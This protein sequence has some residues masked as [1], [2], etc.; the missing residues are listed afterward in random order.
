MGKSSLKCIYLG[1]I[2]VDSNIV[3]CDVIQENNNDEIETDNVTL[4]ESSS[5]NNCNCQRVQQAQIS[6]PR[7]QHLES[8]A[9]TS[10]R[11]GSLASNNE[12]YGDNE[13]SPQKLHQPK[14]PPIFILNV[15]D[16]AKIFNNISKVVDKH[17]FY[18]KSLRDGQ[19]RLS[20]KTVDSYRK[21]VDYLDKN[22]Y[23]YIHNI[24]QLS[25]KIRE[26]L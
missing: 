24:P 11:F 26:S 16:I 17:E 10:N 20:V 19:V 8:G 15:S 6:I 1:S 12:E 21:A 13:V 14:P 7:Q 4:S 22:I 25:T 3:W 5:D 18:Y 23:T 9:F 2:F